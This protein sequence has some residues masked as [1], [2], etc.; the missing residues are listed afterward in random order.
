M[1]QAIAIGIAITIPNRRNFPTS[2]PKIPQTPNG[3]GVGGT[4]VWVI[5]R[6][7]ASATPSEIT[8]FFVTFEIAFAIGARITKPESQKI[9]ID[10][11]NPV[12]PSASSSLPFPNSFKKV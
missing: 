5:T 11:R 2:T 1:V 12:M 8:D 9:G 3:P 4:S 7:A 6:P 10:T